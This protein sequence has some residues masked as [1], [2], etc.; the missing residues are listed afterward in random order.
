[1]RMY[2][3]Q[4]LTM[5]WGEWEMLPIISQVQSPC[6]LPEALFS[7]ASQNSSAFSDAVLSRAISTSS[8]PTRPGPLLP[9]FTPPK[10]KASPRSARHRACLL[11]KYLLLH[12][13]DGEDERQKNRHTERGTGAGGAPPPSSERTGP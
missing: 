6:C 12:S 10:S 4:G 13:R 9:Q 11:T 3:V 7:L 5:G 2:R 1:M 8:H